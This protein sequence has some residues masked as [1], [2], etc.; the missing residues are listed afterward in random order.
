[1]ACAS[2]AQE[3]AVFAEAPS[4]AEKRVEEPALSRVEGPALSGVEGVG[5]RLIAQ[6]ALPFTPR[7]PQMSVRKI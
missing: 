4:E 3:P 1:M 7:V 2:F 5:A 6:W